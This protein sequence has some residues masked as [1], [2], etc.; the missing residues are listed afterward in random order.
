M[1]ILYGVQGT[2]NGHITRARAMQKEFAKTNMQVDW[3]FSGRDRVHYFDMEVFKNSQYRRGLSFCV[4][5]GKVNYFK[6]ALQLNIRQFRKDINRINI[7]NY[8]LIITDFEP[9]TAWAGKK[10][11]IPVLGLGHQYVFNYP[12]PQKRGDFISRYVLNKYAP[13]KT[14]LPLHWHHFNQNILPPMVETQHIKGVSVIKNKVMVYL[15]FENQ[16]EV[17]N[18]LAPLKKYKFVVY[19]PL[20]IESYAENVHFKPLSRNGFMKDL[21]DCDAVI[22]NAGFELSSEVLSLGKRL[23]IKPLTGQVEQ[24]SNAIAMEKLHYGKVLNS[25]NCRY[26]SHFLDIS[27][28]VKINYPN[29]A[30]YIVDWIKQGMPERN[31]DWYSQIWQTVTVE[32][33]QNFIAADNLVYT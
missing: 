21:S 16:Y 1:K 2:G 14:Y 13:A 7:D 12:I 6:T 22:A 20:G 33:S 9:I 24:Q 11:S 26:I 18:S 29:V 8:D 25:L 15:P 17:L 27:D 5:N 10:S 23:L 3:L 30:A 31:S 19:S 4:E 32:R 28:R